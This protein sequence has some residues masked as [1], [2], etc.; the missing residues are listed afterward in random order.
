MAREYVEASPQERARLVV[1][2]WDN[3]NAKNLDGQYVSTFGENDVR[4][5]GVEYG[6]DAET[7]WVDVWVGRKV[8]APTFRIC[9]PRVLVKDASGDVE[10]S[11]TN[12]RGRPVITRF[13]QDPLEAVAEM[14]AG[15]RGIL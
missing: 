5:G 8:G 3:S 10:I 2:A 7:A 11:D 9:N 4:I 12:D 1:E 13:R 14:I 6:D 15:V